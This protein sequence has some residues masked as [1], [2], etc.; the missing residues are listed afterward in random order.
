MKGKGALRTPAR[1]SGQRGMYG[2]CHWNGK[3]IWREEHRW[4]ELLFNIYLT[5]LLT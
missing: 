5:E 2:H 4:R 1:E 3:I